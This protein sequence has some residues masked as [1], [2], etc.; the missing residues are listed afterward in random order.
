MKISRFV[1][2]KP[3]ILGF[4]MG[5]LVLMLSTAL[6]RADCVEYTGTIQEHL[7]AGRARAHQE[8]EKSPV[9]Y[10]ADTYLTSI[11]GA[12]IGVDLE[13][14]VT[15]HFDSAQATPGIDGMDP[16]GYRPGPCPPDEDGDN[17]LSGHDCNDRDPKIHPNATEIC[18]D[19]IDQ[20]CD[21]MDQRCEEPYF[22]KQFTTTLE[23]HFRAG[24][25]AY[26]CHC[27]CFTAIKGSGEN[28]LLLRP[29][30]SPNS[31]VSLYTNDNGATFHQG[32]CGITPLMDKLRDGI[33]Q[34]TGA[35]KNGATDEKGDTDENADLDETG[36][37]DPVGK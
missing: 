25:L 37:K 24:R 6:A 12:K 29:N 4:L 5:S 36:Q 3:S 28:I 33:P 15:L 17:Y 22:C 30:T 34:E 7:D 2:L 16:T 10:Y 9:I 35:E 14:V 31:I 11:P 20:D 21:G 32:L 1:P 23:N 26:F 8:S 19:G 18:G 13:A 27:A